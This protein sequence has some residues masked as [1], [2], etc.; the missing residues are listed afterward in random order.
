LAFGIILGLALRRATRAVV[1]LPAA[2]RTAITFKAIRQV[3]ERLNVLSL[4]SAY[5]V[6]ASTTNV[7]KLTAF[8]VFDLVAPRAKSVGFP[9]G[10]RAN[11]IESVYF[12]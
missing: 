6:A 1:E 7:R 2:I 12:E 4:I 10:S 9:K 3:K 5:R 8:V 11:I